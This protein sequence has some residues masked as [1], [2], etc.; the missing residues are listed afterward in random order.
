[1]RDDKM[2]RL[3]GLISHRSAPVWEK[4]IAS[5]GRDLVH[6]VF[7]HPYFTRGR[8][9]IITA[10]GASEGRKWKTLISRTSPMRR[11]IILGF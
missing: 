4:T 9:K 11:A 10:R 2:P 1:M 8:F 7:G 3:K 5:L 6:C